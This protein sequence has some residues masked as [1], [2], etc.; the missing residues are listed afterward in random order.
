M[1]W[2]IL[3]FILL[4]GLASWWLYRIIKTQKNSFTLQNFTKTLGT[5]GVLAIILIAF[6]G[7]CIVLLRN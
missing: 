5:L 1:N 7:L 6:I 4:A 3:F 2:S